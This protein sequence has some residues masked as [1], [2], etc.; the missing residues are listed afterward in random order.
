MDC[1]DSIILLCLPFLELDS[2]VSLCQSSKQLKEAF[3]EHLSNGK[4]SYVKTWLKER[5][6]LPSASMTSHT[7]ESD[8]KNALN[9]IGWLLKQCC[10]MWGIIPLATKLDLQGALLLAERNSARSLHHSKVPEL[11]INAGARITDEVA[12]QA[13]PVCITVGWNVINSLMQ[14]YEAQWLATGLTPLME[15]VALGGECRV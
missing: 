3:F 4:Q 9:N 1:F 7:P 12:L 15:Y 13:A 8:A 10:S 6:Q 2:F 5:V 14:I 11:L